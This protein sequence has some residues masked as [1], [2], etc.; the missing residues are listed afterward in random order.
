MVE[1]ELVLLGRLELRVRRIT[2]HLALAELVD[3]VDA[4]GHLWW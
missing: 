4:V 1:A 3:L 2:Q